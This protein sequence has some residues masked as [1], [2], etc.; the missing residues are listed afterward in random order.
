MTAHFSITIHTIAIA[1]MI[2]FSV[3]YTLP[4]SIY[5][6]P[7]REISDTIR[8]SA[9]AANTNH[10][11]EFVVP[12]AVTANEV[13]SITPEAGFFTIPAL[14]SHTDIDFL[15]AAT[16]TDLVQRN[17]ATSS[18]SSTDGVIVTSGT[19][20][21]IEVTIT[22]TSTGV[23]P[24]TSRIRVVVGTIAVYQATGTNQIENPS[25]TGT[26]QILV[27]ILDISSVIRDSALTAIAIVEQVGVGPVDTRESDPPFR[28]NG[29]PSGEL[30]FGTLSAE[31]SLNTN[32][33]AVCRHSTVAGVAYDSM[34]VTYPTT[35]QILHA[36]IIVTGLVSEQ[37]YTFYVRC[38]DDEGNKNPDDFVITFSIAP[39]PPP[40]G[41]GG[42]SGGS[43]GGSG[44]NTGSG[45]GGGSGSG[46]GAPFPPNSGQ[47]TL[48]GVAYPDST[49]TI[50]QDGV[51]S[52]TVTTGL[53]GKFNE[54][55]SGLSPGIYTFGV[56][57]TDID[58]NNSATY[59]TTFQVVGGTNNVVSN[60]YIP[61]TIV[62]DTNRVEPGGI[63]TAS[64]FSLT[65]GIVHIWT[66]QQKST[67]FDSDIIKLTATPDAEGRWSTI[68][69]T[70]GFAR[71]THMVKAKS[72]I[73]ENNESDFSQYEFYGA[74][75][76]PDPLLL[77]ADLNRDGFVNLIDFS[78]LLFHWGTNGL[79][80][81]P[82]ADINRDGTVSLIDF[83]I[84]LFQWTG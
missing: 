25:A 75:V 52:R 39:E 66:H 53:D 36:G 5:A 74:G 47:V 9:P 44:G 8:S 73:N 15:V 16:S 2:F 62:L 28:F 21:N 55:V 67:V 63:I 51:V 29:A 13:I 56:F 58:L 26:R 82:P 79:G 64:G 76:D 54:I 83:S 57:A 77:T 4:D 46:S 6:A 65:T 59:S 80:N 49:I 19:S 38:V 43:G 40:G 60:V 11:F 23:I 72:V 32:E 24:A 41:S 7:I 69:D 71:D 10:T 20:G 30:P 50:L 70:T 17:I 84:M 22:S 81:D 31:L 37:T 3:L 78:I 27:R 33:L 42:G 68:I 35:G 48:I 18:S 61:P 14:M 1:S 12:S 45:S 34:T